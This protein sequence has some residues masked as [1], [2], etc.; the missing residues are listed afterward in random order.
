MSKFANTTTAI[1][2]KLQSV[3]VLVGECWLEYISLLLPNRSLYPYICRLLLI[4]QIGYT[5]THYLHIT[6][7]VDTRD[8][9]GYN[10]VYCLHL[11]VGNNMA[12]LMYISNMFQKDI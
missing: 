7:N 12:D 6:H 5:L 9:I 10:N 2:L 3:P 11:N 1:L 4:S 8:P